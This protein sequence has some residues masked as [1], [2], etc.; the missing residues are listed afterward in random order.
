MTH[1]LGEPPPWTTIGCQDDESS[2]SACSSDDTQEYC[3][4]PTSSF[5][6]GS[7]AV[8]NFPPSYPVVEA[9]AEGPGGAAGPDPAAP[10]PVEVNPF[11]QPPNPDN[12][13]AMR[14][15]M[16]LDHGIPQPGTPPLD[17]PRPP[18]TPPPP[19]IDPHTGLPLLGFDNEYF[20]VDGLDDDAIAYNLSFDLFGDD[21]D[22]SRY[23]SDDNRRRLLS[24]KRWLW[25]LNEICKE[26]PI[27]N[28]LDTNKSN[29]NDRLNEIINI[30]SEKHKWLERLKA[31]TQ[32][33]LNN[34]KSL[35]E[36]IKIARDKPRSVWPDIYKTKNPCPGGGERN[37]EYGTCDPIGG[38]SAS[39]KKYV[40][41][42]VKAQNVS[43]KDKVKLTQN[44]N[45][46]LHCL[47]GKM[48]GG[49]STYK[50]LFCG[51]GNIDPTKLNMKDKSAKLDLLN[52][53][54]NASGERLN[55]QKHVR[56]TLENNKDK[57]FIFKKILLLAKKTY[58]ERSPCSSS[59]EI[60]NLESG[61]CVKKW[62]PIVANQTCK[63]DKFQPINL[64][65]RDKN[66]GTSRRKEVI[67]NN[68]FMAPVRRAC[69]GMRW[70]KDGYKKTLP[71]MLRATA[72]ATKTCESI[73]SDVYDKTS[74]DRNKLI[75]TK[76]G[77][78]GKFLDIY[79]IK[80]PDGKF[81][82]NKEAAEYKFIPSTYSLDSKN[83]QWDSNKPW[84]VANKCK[85]SGHGNI[86]DDIG[87]HI[88]GIDVPVCD[89]KIAQMDTYGLKHIPIDSS[90][91]SWW[92]PLW[93]ILHG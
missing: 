19:L 44:A 88:V 90:Q 59:T 55:W 35:K 25:D 61:R 6:G 8:F 30:S 11:Q 89:W 84:L 46:V 75:L 38:E 31:I 41:Q 68:K 73:E 79:K 60:R 52:K 17:V 83:L 29:I 77:E 74:S 1:H 50:N 32:N 24:K 36:I 85:I 22:F 64:P 4:T 56:R 7:G 72:A 33:H 34:T 26:G 43:E 20:Y 65:V 15:A 21:S 47:G 58:I 78:S 23:A 10:G 87:G 70:D 76:K 28:I 3:L 2:E 86:L 9:E 45:K 5:M 12:D 40:N 42:C 93:D 48:G 13:W 92:S 57:N 66:T 14:L 80:K 69:L 63:I 62:K 27:I 49:E 39:M 53:L 16:E 91:R 67:Q 18:I 51:S 81:M 71:N 82:T 54:L 37:P